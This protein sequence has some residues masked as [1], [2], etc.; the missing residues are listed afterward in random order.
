MKKNWLIL[1]G[2][3]AAVTVAGC[4]EGSTGYESG[5]DPNVNPNYDPAAQ[6]APKKDTKGGFVPDLKPDK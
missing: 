4:S 1:L 3:L 6:A 5:K 2:I